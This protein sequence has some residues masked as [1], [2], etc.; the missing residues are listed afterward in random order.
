MCISWS[1]VKLALTVGAAFLFHSLSVQFFTFGWWS[2]WTRRWFAWLLFVPRLFLD[3]YSWV[4]GLCG[5][6]MV[7]CELFGSSL[8]HLSSLSVGCTCFPFFF[9]FFFLSFFFGSR[10]IYLN[11]NSR[12]MHTLGRLQTLF[13]CGFGLFVCRLA[14]WDEDVYNARNPPELAFNG[15]WWWI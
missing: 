7:L 14:A 15:L 13:L 6:F 2:E 12:L 11:A 4:K 3:F 9:F 10:S 5:C 1:I 8:S